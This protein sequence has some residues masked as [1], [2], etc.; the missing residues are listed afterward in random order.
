MSKAV[1]CVIC[2]KVYAQNLFKLGCRSQYRV[3]MLSEIEWI[4]K[5]NYNYSIGY[6]NLIKCHELQPYATVLVSNLMLDIRSRIIH[7]K[8]LYSMFPLK[9]N[10]RPT[11]SI[12]L[13]WQ[14]EDSSYPRGLRNGYWWKGE[15]KGFLLPGS[16]LFLS[17]VVV[18]HVFTLG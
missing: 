17:R 7:K 12:V 2:T 6:Y 3:H 14:F 4:N 18:E 16:V 5:L 15:S 13:E 10:I 9:E 11:W 1:L 8:N